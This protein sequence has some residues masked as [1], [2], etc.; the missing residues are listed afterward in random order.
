LKIPIVGAQMLDPFRLRNRGEC[1]SEE[2]IPS[3]PH[4]SRFPIAMITRPPA[5]SI[6]ACLL[7]L[8]LFLTHE[9]NAQNVVS[10]SPDITIDLG[11]SLIVSDEDVAVDNQLGI[12]VLEN[13]GSLPTESEVVA[14]GLDV[15]GDRLLSFDTTTSLA[16]GIVA[17]PG[18]VIRYDGAIY[19][20]EFDASA[21]GL[22][23]GVATDAASLSKNGLLLSFDTTVDLGGGLIAADEDLVDWDGSTFGLLF[24]G[25]AA[26]VDAALDVDG[27][28]DIG[29]G[30]FLISFDTTGEIA[31]LVFD[32]EDIV[33]YD[34]AIWTL[35]FDA[36][37]ANAN[38]A[39]ADMDAVMVPEPGMLGLL[40]AGCSLLFVFDCR[41]KRA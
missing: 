33:R 14:L 32:D 38:W 20:I 31:G 19:S 29:G 10:A 9:A 23:P 4:N 34:G 16:G 39:A 40:A 3:T 11:A 22:P 30:R 5:I 17:R 12:V 21:A 24:D 6:M 25:T 35:E 41:R 28:Q 27:A 7:L 1:S 26:G 36:S 18:D 13:L 8:S 2:E 15:N 37:V